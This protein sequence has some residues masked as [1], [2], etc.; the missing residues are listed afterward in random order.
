MR[1]VP[2]TWARTFRPL[3]SCTRKSAFGIDRATVP[4]TAPP[5]GEYI[6]RWGLQTGGAWWTTLYNDPARDQWF[7][8]N[9]WSARWEPTQV[10]P[11]WIAGSARSVT[12]SVKNDG[13]RTWN[14]SGTNPVKVG[15]YWISTATG[16]RFDGA[17]K[18]SLPADVPPGGEARV[19]LPVVAPLYPTNY[20][21]TFDLYKEN[22]FWF[23]DKGLRPDD[24]EIA[25]PTRPL[26]ELVRAYTALVSD[27]TRV[28][29]RIKAIYRGRGIGT[30]GTT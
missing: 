9:D 14:A 21:L 19:T 27:S 11:I 1:I 30:A 25:E 20:S 13:G 3:S 17:A 6:V 8:S 10:P 7:R 5:K 24:Q 28:M 26:K 4:F 12:V 29:L 2:E 15:Y 18:M 16:N 22:E 23:R